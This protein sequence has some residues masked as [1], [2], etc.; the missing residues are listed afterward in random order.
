MN[1]A[2]VETEQDDYQTRSRIVSVEARTIRVPL[3]RQTA[4]S[5]RLVTARD[6]TVVRVTTADDRYGIGFCYSGSR[7]GMLV[8]YAVRELFAPLLRGRSALDIEG[9]WRAMYE[10]SLLQGRAGSVMR[11]L[12][13]IDIALWDRNSASAGLPLSRYLGGTSSTT[14][15]AYASGGYYLEGKTPEHLGDEMASYVALGFRAVKMKVGRL[16]PRGEEARIR[17]HGRRL[18]TTCC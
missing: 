16:D 3:D 14:V 4:F 13:I 2:I 8:T 17:Q 10:E 9:L 7:A 5:T 1:Q 15:P 12:S 6:Y 18:A 11:A